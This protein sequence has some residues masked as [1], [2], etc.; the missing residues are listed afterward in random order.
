MTSPATDAPTKQ[1]FAEQQHFGLMPE[2]IHFFQQVH[3]LAPLTLH[4]PGS[5]TPQRIKFFI[6]AETTEHSCT[7]IVSW[8]RCKAETRFI[9]SRGRCR[10]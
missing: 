6:F 8:R 3:Q 4:R 9:L 7:T 1:F 5:F 10:A 2:Q